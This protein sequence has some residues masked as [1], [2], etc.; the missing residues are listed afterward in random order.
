MR[1]MLWIGIPLSFVALC[2]YLLYRGL[3]A[4]HVLGN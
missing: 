3:V 1:L 2:A 4:A